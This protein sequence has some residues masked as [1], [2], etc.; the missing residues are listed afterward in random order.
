MQAPQPPKHPTTKTTVYQEGLAAEGEAIRFARPP[1]NGIVREAAAALQS[2][3][4][5]FLR[6]GAAFGSSQR[7]TAGPRPPK[8]SRVNLSHPCF[9][10][11]FSM[12]LFDPLSS[13]IFSPRWPHLRPDVGPYKTIFRHYIFDYISNSIPDLMLYHFGSQVELQINPNSIR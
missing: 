7:L 12:L 9:P 13:S 11:L 10:L 1:A 2:S 3:D 4:P 6:Q 8:L 5:P